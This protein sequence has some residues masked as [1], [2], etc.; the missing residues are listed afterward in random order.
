MRWDG[1]SWV[2]S[3]PRTIRGLTQTRTDRPDLS[4][5]SARA[6]GGGDLLGGGLAAELLGL[7]GQ[8]LGQLAVAEDLDAV[9]VAALDDAAGAQG[10]LVD[11]VPASKTLERRRC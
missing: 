7:D 4:T 8:G 3:S 6:A 2:G 9:V 5:T 1:A 11:D 10:G